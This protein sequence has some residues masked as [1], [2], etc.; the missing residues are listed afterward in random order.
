[1]GE[2]PPAEVAGHLLLLRPCGLAVG[3]GPVPLQGPLV[4]QLLRA[5]RALLLTLLGHGAALHMGQH[6]TL[7]GEAPLAPATGVGLGGRRG[8]GGRRGVWRSI[9]DLLLILCLLLD[10]SLLILFL[11]LFFTSGAVLLP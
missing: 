3:L 6:A 8:E 5:L 11:L 7:V 1:M 9:R 4:G 10:A 2:G